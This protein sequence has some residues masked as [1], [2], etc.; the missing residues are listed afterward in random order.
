MTGEVWSARSRNTL[1]TAGG[2]FV[3]SLSLEVHMAQNDIEIVHQ[4]VA[5]RY[6]PLTAAASFTEGAP[7]TLNVTGRIVEVGSN[8]DTV[9]GISAIRSTNSDGTVLEVGTPITYY[10]AES[11]SE[12]KSNNFATDGAGTA[13]VPTISNVNDTAGFIHLGGVTWFIDTGAGNHHVQI[14]AIL[15]AANQDIDG[16]RTVDRVASRIQF[17]F[18]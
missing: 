16:P 15:N 5:M 4:K 1:N 8:P 3:V 13:V 14:T 17:R 6:A 18:L 2:D 12:F 9:D 10:P 11:E 7:I